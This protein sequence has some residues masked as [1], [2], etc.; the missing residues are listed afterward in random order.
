MKEEVARSVLK[1]LEHAVSNLDKAH[2]GLGDDADLRGIGMQLQTYS[3]AITECRTALASSL[4]AARTQRHSKAAY[5]ATGTQGCASCCFLNH[6]E[7]FTVTDTG[8]SVCF[9]VALQ[10]HVQQQWQAENKEKAWPEDRS[11]QK[12]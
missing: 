10:Y 2:A 9:G 3:A 12:A 8:C 6:V 4:R 5:D 11:D 7:R 1:Y